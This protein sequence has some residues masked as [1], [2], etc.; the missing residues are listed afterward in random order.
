MFHSFCRF[1]Q[2]LICVTQSRNPQNECHST[3]WCAFYNRTVSPGAL[4]GNSLD[5]LKIFLNLT[6]N[7][8]LVPP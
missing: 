2:L 3:D 4:I 5:G 8:S 1:A 6:S 7:F